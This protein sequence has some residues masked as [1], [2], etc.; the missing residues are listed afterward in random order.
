MS[1]IVY[2]CTPKSCN[3]IFNLTS[4]FLMESLRINYLAVIAS[5][6]IIYILVCVWCVVFG[7][8]CSELT[9]VTDVMSAKVGMSPSTMNIIN[10]SLGAF[11]MGI[12]F[13]SAKIN[14]ATIGA[15]TGL[16]IGFLLVGSNIFTN[17]PSNPDYT[18]L[19]T[20]NILFK[21]IACTI[22]G[23]ILGGWKRYNQ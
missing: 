10:Y 15:L 18:H 11:S 12:I 3:S 9:G 16:L 5:V 22:M 13:K 6:A 19:T 20:L 23:A 7:R 21:I 2:I 1:R 8:S 14:T 17:N 4:S